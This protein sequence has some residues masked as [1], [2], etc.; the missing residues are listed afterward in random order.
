[1]ISEHRVMVTGMGIVSAFGTDIEIFWKKLCG[2]E[3]A[4]KPLVCADNGALPIKYAAQIDFDS[5]IAQNPAYLPESGITDRRGVMGIVAAAKALED[6]GLASLFLSEKR[7]GIYGCS[8]VSDITEDDRHL[9]RHQHGSVMQSMFQQLNDLGSYSGVRCSN[10]GMVVEIARRF[11]LSG[12]V[13]NVNAACAGATHAIG[14]A[15]QAIKRQEAS[16]M[17]AGGA[18]SVISLRTLVG[19]NL[20][21]ATAVTEKW[22]SRLCRPFDKHR[23]GL[24]A[25]EGGAFLVLESEESALRRGAKIYAEIKGYGASLDAYKLTAPHPGGI[26]AE[27]AIRQA[28]SSSGLQLHQIDYINAHGTSTPLN[29]ELETAVIKRIFGTQPPL[30]SSIKSMLGHWIAA[31]GAI[32]AVATVLTVKEQ[33]IPPTINLESPDPLCDLD[34]VPQQGRAAPVHNAITNSFGFG[35]INSCLVIGEYDER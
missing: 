30:V 28:I 20:L 15:C 24:V 26:G 19:L 2:G 25:G 9:V 5:L 8:G 11:G 31:A 10:D 4:V 16:I 21:G 34:Y 1:M 35:G 14:L 33:F 29:D 13:V 18:D 23:S 7:M 27:S 22:G 12:P 17:L 3:S 6:A 32:E